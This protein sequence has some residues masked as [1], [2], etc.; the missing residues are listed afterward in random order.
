MQHRI[1]KP[2]RLLNKYG[3]LKQRGYAT[4]PILHYRRKDVAKKSRLKEWDYYLAYNQDYAAALT[5]GKSL[6]LLLINITLLDFQKKNE[7]TK[8]MVK[9]VSD[10][11]FRMPQ[12]STRG[13]II[14]K[15]RSLDVSIRIESN[16]R[17]LTLTK[18]DSLNKAELELSLV[19]YNEPKDSMV[20][21][22]PFNEDKRAFYYNR[23][24]IGMRASGY[25]TLH[26]NTYLF[27]PISSYALLDWGRGVWPYRTNWYWGAAQGSLNGYH[28]G[29][30][31]G[32]GFGDTSAAT[33]NMLFFNGIAHKLQDISFHIPTTN[34]GGFDYM[35]PWTITSSDQRLELTFEPILERKAFLSAIVISTEQHQVFGRFRGIAILDDGTPIH[36]TEFLGFAER[37]INRW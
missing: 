5:I 11:T 25:V 32:Y 4:T 2:S 14:Y 29:F 34:T 6:N 3:E 23:K 22:T 8:S 19:L 31:L 1:S 17:I 26:N 13:N 28:F 18:R 7:T 36:I 33:E 27:S 37:V 21:A 20:I 15:D 12:S 16:I 35:Q 9:L 30:N 10:R 24:I